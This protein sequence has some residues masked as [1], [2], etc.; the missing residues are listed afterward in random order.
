MISKYN[1]I[2]FILDEAAVKNPNIEWDEWFRKVSRIFKHKIPEALLL[3][4]SKQSDTL[5]MLCD[6]HRDNSKLKPRSTHEERYQNWIKRRDEGNQRVV[7]K[8]LE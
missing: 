6:E 5:K 7:E 1:L 2:R 4:L 8:R 3:G